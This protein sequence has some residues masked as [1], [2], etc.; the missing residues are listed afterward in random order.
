MECNAQDMHAGRRISERRRISNMV[1]PFTNKKAKQFNENL[2]ALECLTYKTGAFRGGYETRT[3]TFS[4]GK[5]KRVIEYF[6]GSRKEEAK[7]SYP[8]TKE[9][10]I[11]GLRSFKI[12]EWKETY[13]DPRALDG[14][15][16]EMIFE[17][18]G[19]ISSAKYYGSNAYPKNYRE[20]KE[21]LRK[22]E[23]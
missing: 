20:V 22:G 17:Y 4:E 1:F 10:F 2:D 5:T 23:E 14:W 19:N 21:F 9:D 15:Y 3:Y 8:Y 18:A 6:Y 12:G 11:E 13:H 7:I 16:W